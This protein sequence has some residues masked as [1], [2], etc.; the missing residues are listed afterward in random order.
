MDVIID[1]L[2]FDNEDDFEDDDLDDMI[3]N[4]I[5]HG[6]ALLG[7]RAAL[8]GAFQLD[9]LNDTQCLSLFRFKKEH[10]QPL[11]MALGI[12]EQIFFNRINLS[13]K[14]LHYEACLN[15]M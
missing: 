9:T 8:Y 14:Y 13:G 5:L 11:K 6:E 3:L 2:V 7:N 15:L 10:L 12:P 4:H 1:N